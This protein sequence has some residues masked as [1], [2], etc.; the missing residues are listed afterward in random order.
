M[1]AAAAR[2]LA[3]RA[4]TPGCPRTICTAPRAARAG[5]NAAAGITRSREEIADDNLHKSE[6]ASPEL[7]S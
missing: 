6:G 7:Y 5:A 4:P 1:F 3:P 2:R